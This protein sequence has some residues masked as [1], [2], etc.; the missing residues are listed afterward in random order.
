MAQFVLDGDNTLLLG[1]TSPYQLNV[2]L[3][4]YSKFNQYFLIVDTVEP[5]KDSPIGHKNVLS[6]DKWS[7]ITGSIIAKCSSF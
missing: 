3:D 4:V 2:H 5:F 7:L 1:G 6:Q